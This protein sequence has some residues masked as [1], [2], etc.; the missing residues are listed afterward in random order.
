M[1]MNRHWEKFEAG[2]DSFKPLKWL[3]QHVTRGYTDLEVYDLDETIVLFTY[4][5]LKHYI[6]WQCEH[7]S[8]CPPDLDPAAWLNVLRKI[9]AAFDLQYERIINPET[10]D[11]ENYGRWIE[12]IQQEDVVI[13]E[14]MTL[15]GKYLIELYG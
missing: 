5:R 15:F 14:G 3:W 8:S 10:H 4:P 7:G 13:N 12:R 1:G 9:E 11:S 2:R 6:E